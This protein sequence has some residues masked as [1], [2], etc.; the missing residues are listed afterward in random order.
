MRKEKYLGNIKYQVRH[1]SLH[2]VFTFIVSKLINFLLY[3]ES[4]SL[5]IFILFFGD[6]KTHIQTPILKKQ[7]SRSVELKPTLNK[8]VKQ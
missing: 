1:L 8:A 6:F 5:I 7:N 3:L 2:L 4:T